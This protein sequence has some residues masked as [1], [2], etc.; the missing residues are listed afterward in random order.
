MLKIREEG[1][2][3][4]ILKFVWNFSSHNSIFF[5]A[6]FIMNAFF[7]GLLF[8]FAVFCVCYIISFKEFYIA[9]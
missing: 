4:E 5:C 2:D 7:L 6:Q 8:A 9:L 1:E 3:S